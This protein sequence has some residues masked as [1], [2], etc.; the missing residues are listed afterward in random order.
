MLCIKSPCWFISNKPS[1]QK[2]KSKTHHFNFCIFKPLLLNPLRLVKR[3]KASGQVTE[4]QSIM[5]FSLSQ[6]IEWLDIAFFKNQYIIISY[7]V[8]HQELACDPLLDQDPLAEN[9]R[10]KL[11]CVFNLCVIPPPNLFSG[12][13]D[14]L[15]FQY[16]ASFSFTNTELKSTQHT[17]KKNYM[18]LPA[19]IG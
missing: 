16:G 4:I 5:S 10:P 14:I 19:V 12:T 18:S 15:T 9:A 3:D 1:F 11:L 8:T 6:K 17:H 13:F 7:F 2:R